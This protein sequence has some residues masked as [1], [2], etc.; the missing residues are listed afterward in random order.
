[1]QYNDCIIPTW[2]YIALIS[3]DIYS[4]YVILT[5]YIT[6]PDYITVHILCRGS[7][8]KTYHSSIDMLTYHSTLICESG[9]VCSN[10]PILKW[11]RLEAPPPP[12]SFHVLWTRT[13][14][15]VFCG[16]EWRTFRVRSFEIKSIG[17]CLTWLKVDE[18]TFP[19][20]FHT[21]FPTQSCGGACSQSQG[22]RDTSWGTPWIG[23]WKDQPCGY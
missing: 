17:V 8:S 9:T 20:V 13:G 18:Y 19:S 4:D 5:D 2:Y 10:P 21:A 3:S 7:A 16:G 11:H 12:A 6:I 22:T 14:M 1:M 15:L 23:T